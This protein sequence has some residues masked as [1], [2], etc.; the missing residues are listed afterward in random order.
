MKKINFIFGLHNHQPVG[1]FG[2]CFDN[3]Y[4]NA[5][6]PFL[7][8]VERH[9]KMKIC[10]HFSGI[11]LDYLIKNRPQYVEIL[12]K[13][14]DRGQVEILTGGY[15]EPILPSIPEDDRNGQIEKLT[16]LIK[17]TFG[18]TPSGLWPA[19][20]V[21]EPQLVK[22]LTD[23][24]I[25]YAVLDD[26]HFKMLGF[27]DEKLK[28]R[29]V[30]EESG[31]TASIFPISKTLRYSIPF[32]SPEETIEILRQMADDSGNAVALSFDDG[33][34][35]GDWPETYKTCY[36]EKWL[37]RFFELIEIN[38][39]W[40]NTMTLGEANENL[41]ALGLAYLP[42][43]SYPEMM[44]WSLPEKNAAVEMNKNSSAP[45]SGQVKAAGYWRNFLVKYP[46]AN[47]MHKKMLHVSDQVNDMVRGKI[48]SDALSHLWAGQCNCSY[49]HG[50]FGGLYLPHLR[51]AVYENLIKAENI[52]FSKK[53]RGKSVIRQ[54]VHD[55]NLDGAN[56]VLVE[57][58][59]YNFYIAPEKGMS[60][61][62]IDDKKSNSNLLNVLSRKP[63]K[64]HGTLKDIIAGKYTSTEIHEKYKIKDN[65]EE[66]QKHLNY[67]NYLKNSFIDHFL[68][69]DTDIFSV[70]KNNYKEAGN[71]INSRYKY[72]IE[73]SSNGKI[74]IESSFEG[75]IIKNGVSYPIRVKKT[76]NFESNSSEIKV[77]YLI[78]N[79]SGQ[80][81]DCHYACEL[82]L[83]LH[84]SNE[85]NQYFYVP[86]VELNDKKSTALGAIEDVNE[87]GFADKLR[88]LDITLETSEDINLWR[89]P[90]ETVS[91]SDGGF[92]K[93]IQGVTLF[94]HKKI[95]LEKNEFKK[96]SF[97][98]NMNSL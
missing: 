41:P 31:K 51:S 20:R 37:E 5:Y 91:I 22:T 10:L 73:E 97:K 75:K 34:K 74:K 29:Y 28:G 52:A 57:N 76:F 77:D 83:G 88:N 78:T 40:I 15:Y 39:D 66:L 92:E 90:I 72:K 48:K 65:I 30:T 7:E 67:D 93:I 95:E 13:L 79:I 58:N 56:E 12:K 42:C 33:E 71:F 85:N 81:L 69:D 98:L 45:E 47:N 70:Y 80:K 25:K 60:V 26:S 86:G 89:F 63:E 87:F 46:E 35:F 82:N 50:W 96:I 53:H 9:P 18:T 55:F 8:A 84:D 94:L 61:F 17:E 6:L 27:T 11:L 23:N 36:E 21:W 64:Y 38:S 44:E 1:N 2:F 14:V 68:D 24:S 4:N 54:A 3:A 19:E 16:D 43:A 32:K 62:E 59:F 49:W